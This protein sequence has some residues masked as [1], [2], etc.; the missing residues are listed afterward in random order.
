MGDMNKPRNMHINH[1]ILKNQ[2][3][4]SFFLFP[5]ILGVIGFTADVQLCA[6]PFSQ[7]HKDHWNYED[8]R[9]YQ[10]IQRILLLILI[11]K[12]DFTGVSRLIMNVYLFI[13]QRTRMRLTPPPLALWCWT[14]WSRSHGR[15]WSFISVKK[16]HDG[17]LG[18][19]PYL[20]VPVKV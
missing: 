5:T 11:N 6:P 4:P 12:H 19:G 15:L 16:E 1:S 7:D 9:K 10:S 18:W 13:F 8:N 3:L 2:R 20:F 17:L 14:D